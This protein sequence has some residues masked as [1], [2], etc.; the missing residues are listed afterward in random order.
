MRRAVIAFFVLRTL[1]QSLFFITDNE[2]VF[3][4]FP[5]FLEPLF[6]VYATILFSSEARRP[7][8]L[9]ATRS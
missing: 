3:L 6:L 1:G 4:L 9:P 8:F 2:I 5:N 7:H